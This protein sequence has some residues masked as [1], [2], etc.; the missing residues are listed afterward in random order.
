MSSQSTTWAPVHANLAEEGASGVEGVEDRL[1]AGIVIGP[2]D[3]RRPPRLRARPLVSRTVSGT[4][5]EADAATVQGPFR[6]N[7]AR[8]LTGE[9][10]YPREQGD[11][12]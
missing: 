4:A 7:S 3:A 10:D 2:E 11:D 5:R 1:V 12:L 6:E 8:R 9:Q